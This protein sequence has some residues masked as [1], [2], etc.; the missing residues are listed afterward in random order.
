MT[1]QGKKRRLAI[2]YDDKEKLCPSNE[3]AIVKFYDAALQSNFAVNIIKHYDIYRLFE[4]DA[5]FIRSTTAIDND[6]YW[7]SV[8]ASKLGLVVIDDP[9]SIEIGSNKIAQ[10]KLFDS[11]NIPTPRTFIADIENVEIIQ[12]LIKPPYVFK[13]PYGSFS[14][15]VYKV[16]S[17]ETYKNFC[18]TMFQ[19]VKEFIVQEFIQTE[20]DWRIGI[21]KNEIIFAC[22][23]YMT[24]GHWK[25]I[26]HNRNGDF[27]DGE[28]TPIAINNIP[29]L[30]AY[31]ALKAA[32]LLGKGLYGVDIKEKN[33][34][35]YVIEVNDNPNIDAGT[36]D[37]LVG[38]ELYMKI[39]RHFHS[40][41]D[42]LVHRE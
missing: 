30:I 29:P 27:V 10:Q 33:G 23:Y 16:T 1:Y 18:T 12:T 21:L 7:T 34:N 2:L 42:L 6:T 3:K 38:D 35:I 15:G 36:E 14:N 37:S 8:N 40:E 4:Y 31:N 13:N 25:V 5:L 41:L 11:H 24:K 17:Q 39:I 19:K 22:K 9:K 26:K 20:Y 32:S 28:S